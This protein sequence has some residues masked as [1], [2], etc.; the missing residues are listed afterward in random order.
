MRVF[1]I[2]QRRLS[3]MYCIYTFD[4]IVST[5]VHSKKMHF[6]VAS[7]IL[8][9]SNE[10]KVSFGFLSNALFWKIGHDKT[11]KAKNMKNTCLF[12][13]LAKRQ[14]FSCQYHENLIQK[15]FFCC[16]PERFTKIVHVPDTEKKQNPNFI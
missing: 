8:L 7:N 3:G 6:S 5:V 16:Y 13:L 2:T 14:V 1:E 10:K 11:V 15:Q 9:L 4:N 12:A